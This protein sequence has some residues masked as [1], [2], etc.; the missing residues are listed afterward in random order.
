MS[1]QAVE[2]FVVPSKGLTLAEH[3]ELTGL[4]TEYRSTIDD[5]RLTLLESPVP[6]RIAGYAFMTAANVFMKL[7]LIYIAKRANARGPN[8]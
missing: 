6:I 5:M 2:K 1:D 3:A 4:V 7:S 8:E